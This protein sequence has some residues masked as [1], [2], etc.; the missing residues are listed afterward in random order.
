MYSSSQTLFR[1]NKIDKWKWYLDEPSNKEPPIDIKNILSVGLWG[2]NSR[3]D[4][5]ILDGENKIPRR[6]ASD[7]SGFN[8]HLHLLTSNGVS[9]SLISFSCFY[10]TGKEEH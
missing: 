10:K 3:R 6:Q 1:T 4:F 8:K 7:V 2:F 5:I 9:I